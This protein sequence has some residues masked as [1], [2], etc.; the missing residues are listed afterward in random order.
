MVLFNSQLYLTMGLDLR[1]S[2]LL[3]QYIKMAQSKEHTLFLARIKEEFG[4]RSQHNHP[5]QTN[6]RTV[7]SRVTRWPPQGAHLRPCTLLIPGKAR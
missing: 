1:L 7:N 2:N 4:G 5:R 3:D 6:L